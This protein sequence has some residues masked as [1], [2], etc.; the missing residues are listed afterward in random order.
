MPQVNITV[1]INQS[2]Y[3]KDPLSTELG[4]K[5]IQQAIISIDEIGFEEFNFK[6]LASAINSTE[7][8]VYRY[9]ENKYKLLAYLVAW[10]WDFMHFMILMDIRNVTNAKSKLTQSI[11]TLVQSLDSSI[12]TDFIDQ[13]K[14]HRVIVENANKLYHT[15]NVDELNK[16]GYYGNYKKIVKLIS[17]MILDIDPKFK[18][19]VAFATNII[20]H[21]LNNEYY[22]QH[23]PSL[24]DFTSKEANARL[25]T[26]KM[27][28]YLINK[29]LQ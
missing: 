6:K 15:K 9:F 5:I 22:M 13:F 11:T 23:L 28:E 16:E 25:E 1:D 29:V 14:L 24:T 8:S 19:P 2:I 4:R 10:Y 18:Y 21:S 27:L 26:I 20:E 17:Q 7:A 3:L 12:T